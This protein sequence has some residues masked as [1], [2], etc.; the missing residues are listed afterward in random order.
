[1]KLT[2]TITLLSVFTC[3]LAMGAC[4]HPVDPTNPAL[5][6]TTAPAN[7]APKPKMPEQ[8]AA[9]VAERSQARWNAGMKGDWIAA[10][11]FLVPE[12]KRTQPL[13]NFLAGMAN[14]KY[15]NMK[16]I[17]VIAVNGDKA[18]V[19]SGGLWTPLS[20]ELAKV[21]REPGQT[22]TQEIQMIESW[23]WVDNDWSFVRPQRDTE[24][25]AE[26]PELLKK[27]DPAEPQPKE[28]AK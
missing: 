20:P 27:K 25:F 2:T 15:E 6:G 12:G 22:F 19:R 26:H 7:A 21:K 17:E 10:Y 3:A 9:R 18:Y 28:P 4:D 23:R 13:A 16:V 8:N 11:D 1:M 24:F 14:H 5:S